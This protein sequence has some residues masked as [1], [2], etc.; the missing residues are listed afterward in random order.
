MGMRIDRRYAAMGSPTRMSDPLT[1]LK[2]E[3]NEDALEIRNLAHFLYDFNPFAIAN[4]QTS[5]IVSPILE[6]LKPI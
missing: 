1:A 4:R 2:V 6:S 5:R 3:P